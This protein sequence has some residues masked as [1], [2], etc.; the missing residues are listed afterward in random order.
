MWLVDH[1]HDDEHVTEI[2]VLCSLIIILCDGIPSYSCG[3]DRHASVAT[4][5]ILNTPTSFEWTFICIQTNNTVHSGFGFLKTL[6]QRSNDNKKWTKVLMEIPI[7]Q[8]CF[9]FPYF[10]RFQNHVIITEYPCGCELIETIN[11]MNKGNQTPT[12]KD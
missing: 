1:P 11:I 9:F 12:E 6:Q 8:P 5:D 10:P 4:P 2:H 3:F 7:F